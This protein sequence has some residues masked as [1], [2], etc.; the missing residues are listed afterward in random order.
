MQAQITPECFLNTQS[1]GIIQVGDYMSSQGVLEVALP[2]SGHLL[3]DSPG[4]AIHAAPPI[5]A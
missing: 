5:L 3:I 2:H 1:G 4:P